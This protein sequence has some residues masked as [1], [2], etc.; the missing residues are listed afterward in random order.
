MTTPAQSNLRQFPSRVGAKSGIVGPLDQIR[1]LM[2]EF[3]Q[4]AIAENEDIPA[5]EW[6]FERFLQ[7]AA[8]REKEKI[9]EK[10]HTD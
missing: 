4:D 9:D 6:R 7:W 5:Y 10:Q 1:D 3:I 2:R 8:R